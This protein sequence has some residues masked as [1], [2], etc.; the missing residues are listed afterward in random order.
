MK[1]SGPLGRNTPLR[2]TGPPER[3]T[4]LSSRASTRSRTRDADLALARA[5]TFLRSRGLCEA[6]WPGCQVVAHHAHHRLRRSHGGEHTPENLLA[7]CWYCHEQIHANPERA[8]AL[9]HLLRS[10][11]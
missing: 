3:R 2:R 9:G 8:Y 1:R 6:S 5:D 4:P 10:G 7:C 11:G